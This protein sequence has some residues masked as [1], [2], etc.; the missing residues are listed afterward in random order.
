MGPKALCTQA[1]HRHPEAVMIMIC[2]PLLLR[3]AVPAGPAC[4]AGAN[5]RR[6]RYQASPS[7][8]SMATQDGLRPWRRRASP[9]PTR[10]GTYTTST[11][12]S[13]KA[14][15]DAHVQVTEGPP[16][17]WIRCSSP[18]HSPSP[19]A[20]LAD[21]LAVERCPTLKQSRVPVTVVTGFLGSGKT[22]L[23]NHILSSPHGKRF[24]VRPHSLTHPP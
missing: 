16:S 7:R 23:L 4:V 13:N 18:T 21:R 6:R 15:C 9:Q 11:R 12:N 1:V 10:P 3:A 17:S 2:I 5:R 8:T 24:A 20:A 22:S 14:S 19:E